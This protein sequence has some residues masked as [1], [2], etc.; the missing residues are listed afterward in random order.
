MML[1]PQNFLKAQCPDG[2]VKYQ[3]SEKQLELFKNFK[4][5]TFIALN[6]NLAFLCN[7]K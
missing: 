3:L 5:K 2:N 6:L 7:C 1:E 4:S